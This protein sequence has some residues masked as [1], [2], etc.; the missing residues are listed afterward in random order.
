MDNAYSI[1]DLLGDFVTW[2]LI[3]AFVK[4]MLLYGSV[5]VA[6][7]VMRRKFTNPKRMYVYVLVNLATVP[8]VVFTI[9]PYM[10]LRERLRF[11]V[12][13]TDRKVIRDVLSGI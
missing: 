12:T 9:L 6:A 4:T 13:Y 2:Y 1:F 5:G 7:G 3:L 11:F 8:I 10:L